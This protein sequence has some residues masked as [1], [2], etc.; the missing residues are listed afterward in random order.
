MVIFTTRPLGLD[1]TLVFFGLVEERLTFA[2]GFFFIELH[3]RDRPTWTKMEQACGKAYFSES[4]L[5]TRKH[6]AR[7]PGVFPRLFAQ[8]S[9]EQTASARLGLPRAAR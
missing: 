5:Y 2:A 6:G 1:F 7:Q 9:A 3:P 4:T 8:G